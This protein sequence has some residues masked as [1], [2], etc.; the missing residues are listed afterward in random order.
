MTHMT[1]FVPYG[2]AANNTW[3]NVKQGA[4]PTTAAIIEAL[5]SKEDGMKLSELSC[6]GSS[7]WECP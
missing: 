1:A 5:P 4:R 6:E 3:N 7:S 2:T